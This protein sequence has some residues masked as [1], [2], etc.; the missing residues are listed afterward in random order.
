PAP[1]ASSATTRPAS[2]GWAAR[3]AARNRPPRAR[4][5][6]RARRTR[7]GRRDAASELRP[8]LVLRQ[9]DL[10]HA[11][12]LRVEEVHDLVAVQLATVDEHVR[13]ALDSFLVLHH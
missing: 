10:G 11:Q 12:L 2:S 8:C 3:G 13:N 4:T 5:P 1:R 9:V 6:V 7:A